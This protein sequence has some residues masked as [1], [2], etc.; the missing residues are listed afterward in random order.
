[1]KNKPNQTEER[2]GLNFTCLTWPTNDNMKCVI[3]NCWQLKLRQLH[4][5]T[6]MS[7]AS[8]F[9]CLASN[10]P[11]IFYQELSCDTKQFS[12][13]F[14]FLKAFLKNN[15]KTM[16]CIMMWCC[17]TK[18]QVLVC[19]KTTIP[20]QITKSNFFSDNGTGTASPF[21]H[22]RI[23]VLLSMNSCLLQV[24]RLV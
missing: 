6:I 2:R 9:L 17:S 8:V 13:L 22:Q 18:W 4:T 15:A 16:E 1:M 23:I 11:T 21:G 14:F 10:K 12:S 7:T 20:A 5:G 3:Y 24:I 19:S